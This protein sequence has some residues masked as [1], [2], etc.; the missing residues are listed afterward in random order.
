M[1]ESDINV[2]NLPTS[3]DVDDDDDSQ[4]LEGDPSDDIDDDRRRLEGYSS[5]REHTSSRKRN[6]PSRPIAGLDMPALRRRLAEDVEEGVSR[7]RLEDPD[8]DAKDS[9]IRLLQVC[10]S[11]T[12]RVCSIRT[13]KTNH[14]IEPHPP[15]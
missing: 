15:R 14:V 5:G 12:R 1:D 11:T 3:E 6:P 8:I 13:E 2:A 7:A 9:D 10:T 4:R